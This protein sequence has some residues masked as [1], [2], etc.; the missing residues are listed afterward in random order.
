M[1]GLLDHLADVVPA[2]GLVGCGVRY[3]RE[4]RGAGGDYRGMASF[5]WLAP[6]DLADMVEAFEQRLSERDV[7]E[8]WAWVHGSCGG[9]ERAARRRHLHGERLPGCLMVRPVY[10]TAAP[11]NGGGRLDELAGVVGLPVDVDVAERRPGDRR[12]YAPTIADAVGLLDPF[13]PSVLLDAGG[14]VV[15]VWLLDEPAD[16][17]AARRLGVDLVDSIGDACAARGWAFDSPPP[18]SAW[19]KW[20]GTVDAFRRHT[21]RQIGDGPVWS[22]SELRAAVPARFRRTRRPWRAAYP[23]AELGR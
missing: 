6:A 18:H 9:P 21:T 2:D 22:F 3:L 19:V 8:L 10:C 13:G 16:P 23:L 4:P 15:A 5:H 7:A 1:A 11:A 20:P 17:H 12:R 14:G